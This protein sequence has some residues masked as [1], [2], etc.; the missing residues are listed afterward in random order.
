MYW[1]GGGVAIYGGGLVKGTA[2]LS[3]ATRMVALR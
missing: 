3:V 1:M 2:V